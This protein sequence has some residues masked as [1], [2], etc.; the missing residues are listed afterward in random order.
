M[1][2]QDAEEDLAEG[3]KKTTYK[4]GQDRQVALRR[5]LRLQGAY[6]VLSESN[7]R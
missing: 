2:Q 7:E 6:C 1:G 5:P 3:V 4:I